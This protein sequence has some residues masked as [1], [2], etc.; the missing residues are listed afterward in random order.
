M[1]V[2]A[3]MVGMML[4]VGM[5]MT[6]G[7]TQAQAE[8][9]LPSQELLSQMGLSGIQVMTDAEA[10]QVR[11]SG[12]SRGGHGHHFKGVHRLHKSIRKFHIWVKKFHKHVKKFRHRVGKKHW[13]P[14][15]HKKW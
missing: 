6:T 15:P 13:S 10:A 1:R 4:V 3:P 2:A 8:S 7:A 14:R 9:G 12:F 11:G 5:V